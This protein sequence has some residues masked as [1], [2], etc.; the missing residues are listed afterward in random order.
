VV[1]PDSAS[2]AV[3]KAATNIN[4][5]PALAT[6]KAVWLGGSDLKYWFIIDADALIFQYPIELKTEWEWITSG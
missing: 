4:G 3:V 6:G 2:I 5:Y 1:S